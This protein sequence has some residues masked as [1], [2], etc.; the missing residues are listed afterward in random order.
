MVLTH[1]IQSQVVRESGF[2]GVEGGYSGQSCR[3]E[4]RSLQKEVVWWSVEE[5]E[6]E[7]EEE[8]EEEE[9]EDEKG[10]EK[11][12]KEKKSLKRKR[13]GRKMRR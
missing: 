12:E 8:E 5:E 6:E 1:A 7:G 9:E 10:E 3:P 4:E 2:E 13:T 11:K